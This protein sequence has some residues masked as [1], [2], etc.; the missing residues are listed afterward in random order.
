MILTM[1]LKLLAIFLK[2]KVVKGVA[3]ILV[4]LICKK[5]K[6]QP[7]HAYCIGYN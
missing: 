6:C 1:T 2:D 7:K 4:M 3:G 5:I